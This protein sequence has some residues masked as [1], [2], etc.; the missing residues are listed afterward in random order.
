MFGYSTLMHTKTRIE[1][2]ASFKKF[3]KLIRKPDIFQTENGGEFNNE[4]MKVYLKN[5][6]IEYIRGSSYITQIKE[7]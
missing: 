6:K 1:V 5:Q 3:L 4:E 7:Q 2:L